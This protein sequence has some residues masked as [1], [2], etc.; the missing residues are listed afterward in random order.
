[1]ESEVADSV[2]FKNA[3]MVGLQTNCVLKII[4]R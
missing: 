1:M 3:E 2:V 4:Q